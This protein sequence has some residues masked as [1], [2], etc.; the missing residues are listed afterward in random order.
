MPKQADKNKMQLQA[1]QQLRPG[2]HFS[3]NRLPVAICWAPFV[4]RL[5]LEAEGRGCFAFSKLKDGYWSCECPGLKPGDRYFLK[6]N[7]KKVFPDPASLSQPDGVHQASQCVDLEAIKK[8]RLAGWKGIPLKD[9]VIYELHVGTFSPAGTFIGV[10]EKLPYLKSL[11]VNAIEIM[12]VASFPGSR[13]WGYDGV[14][15]YSVQYSYG[16]ALCLAQLVR[17]CHEQGMAVILDVVFNHLGPEGNYLGH[18]GPYFNKRHKTP[19]G[20]AIN[21]D[22]EDC[23][24]VRHYFIENALMWLRD[25][26]IDGLRLDAIHAIIDKSRKHFLKELSEKVEKLNSVKGRR[27][28]LIAESDLNDVR[29]IDKIDNEG[30]GIDSQWCDDWHHSLHALLTRERMGY[31]ADFGNLDHLV[32]T[33]NH[34]FVYDGIFSGYRNKVFGTSTK[35]RPGHHF[36]VYAQNHDQVGNRIKGDRLSTILSFESLKLAAAAL[37][38]SP[39]VPMLFMGEEYGEESPFLF[40]TSHGDKQLVGKVR[41]GRKREYR[42]FMKDAELPDPQAEESFMLSKLKWDFPGNPQKESLLAF[43]KKCIGLRKS[44]RILRPGTRE[45]ILARKIGKEAMLLSV[46]GEMESFLAVFNFSAETF[47]ANLEVMSVGKAVLLLYSAHKQW[48]SR[49]AN[50]H[51]PAKT[52]DGK[53]PEVILEPRSVAVYLVKN[54]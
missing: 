47:S 10:A 54:I 6:I 20:P 19:W 23:E 43:Y 24:A 5:E 35:G 45:N 27:H 40:F 3:E 50:G 8:Q 37:L 38:F 15:P 53:A 32:K 2:I 17:A 41:C 34:A 46:K 39:F 7:G 22:G 26:D 9:M 48:G 29:V 28:F 18:F 13:N 16:G 30:F 33:F 52:Q 51:N 14:F 21:F 12:P 31:Y 11:G 4:S 42:A 36:V 44:L 25:F 49:V 1:N